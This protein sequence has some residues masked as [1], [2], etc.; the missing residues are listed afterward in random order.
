[1]LIDR[2][3]VE[4]MSA[5]RAPR[6]APPT[7]LAPAIVRWGP[8]RSASRRLGAT[9]DEADLILARMNR[10]KR[11]GIKL[12]AQRYRCEQETLSGSSLERFLQVYR[13]TVHQF[14]LAP[15]TAYIPRV[16]ARGP[17]PTR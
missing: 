2:P 6:N 11:R 10:E 7:S 15:G 16:L 12:G 5:A 8:A 1:M 3:P 14:G 4:T 17:L 9:A 13:L